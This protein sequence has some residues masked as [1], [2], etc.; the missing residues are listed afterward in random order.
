MEELYK[1][2]QYTYASGVLFALALMFGYSFYIE[3]EESKYIEEQLDIVS[4]AILTLFSGY[5][6][7]VEAPK[8]K[9]TAYFLSG[10]F[11]VLLMMKP[12]TAGMKC[13]SRE[14][15]LNDYTATGNTLNVTV[16]PGWTFECKSSFIFE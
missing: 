6:Y 4:G 2:A 13:Y 7:Y 5:I 12:L 10:V 15:N 1:E 11:L 16:R 9:K 14:I 8:E 3:N